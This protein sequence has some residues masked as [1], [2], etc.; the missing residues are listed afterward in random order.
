MKRSVVLAAALAVLPA[1]AAPGNK[2]QAQGQAQASGNYMPGAGMMGPAG[3][4]GHGDTG[5]YSDEFST[6]GWPSSGYTSGCTSGSCGECGDDGCCGECEYGCEAECGNSWWDC[7]G[8][9]GGTPRWYFTADYLYVRA[10]FSEALAYIEEDDNLPDAT[11]TFHE[12]NFQ[13]ESSYRFG[14]GYKLDC[15]DEEVRFMFTRLSSFA[16]TTAPPGSIV[17]YESGNE[18]GP[19]LISADVDAKSFDLEYRKTIPLGGACGEC[20]DCC[21]TACDPCGCGDACCAPACPAWDVT[22]SGGVRFADVNWYRNYNGLDEDFEPS[23][24]TTSTLS[25]DGGGPRVGLEGRRYFGSSNWCSAYL[26]GDISVL[27]GQMHQQVQRVDQNEFSITQTARARRIIPVTEIEAG[28]TAQLTKRS[29]LSAGYLFSAWHDLGFR[30]E[31]VTSAATLLEN[32]YDDAN[33][34][35]FDGFFVRLEVGY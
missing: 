1:L 7:C 33:I 11:D 21:D 26:K 22:W 15:C 28:A 10:S 14:G 19:T 3:M 16:N 12:L 32:Q 5:Y 20:G 29:F 2:A 4:T 13:H 35:G 8:L 9:V 17:P 23:R 30:D 34:L 27:L 24:V 31:F 18:G 25:F 6:D